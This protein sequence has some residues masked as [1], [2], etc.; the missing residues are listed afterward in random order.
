MI[1]AGEAWSRTCH[2]AIVKLASE[3]SEL[4]EQL[5]GCKIAAIVGRKVQA[6]IEE[7]IALKCTPAEGKKFV[8]CSSLETFSKWRDEILEQVCTVIGYDALPSR[9][10]IDVLY[11]GGQVIKVPIACLVDEIRVRMLAMAKASA[12]W[13]DTLTEMPAEKTLGF[14]TGEVHKQVVFGEDLF[15][16]AFSLP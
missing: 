1:D 12:I 14:K 13:H 5:W 7:Q 10:E 15:F 4:G 16:K 9:R 8:D 2:E 3:S 6:K 11:R